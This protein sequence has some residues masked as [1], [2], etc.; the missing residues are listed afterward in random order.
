MLFIGINVASMKSMIMTVFCLALH[1]KYFVFKVSFK[2]R[3][4][5]FFFL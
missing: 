4:F 2:S 3:A 1:L 5:Q